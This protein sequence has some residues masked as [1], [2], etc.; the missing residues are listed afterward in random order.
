MIKKGVASFEYQSPK[1]VN[2]RG[3]ILFNTLAPLISVEYY[4]KSLK[5]L[6]QLQYFYCNKLPFMAI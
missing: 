3:R 6:A 1:A 5:S 2:T 4:R